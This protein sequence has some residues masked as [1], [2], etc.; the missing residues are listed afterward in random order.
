M[1]RQ[2][3]MSLAA[4]LVFG[5]FTTRRPD[6]RV[7]VHSSIEDLTPIPELGGGTR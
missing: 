3:H 2:R 5:A 7:T 4:P 6:Q 1:Y